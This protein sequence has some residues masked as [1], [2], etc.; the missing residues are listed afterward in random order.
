MKLGKAVFYMDNPELEH[1]PIDIEIPMLAYQ[2]DRETR[3]KTLSVVIQAEKVG[4]Q[5]L[6]GVRYF[7][8]GN[9]VCAL[10]EIEFIK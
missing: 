2:I 6:V 9:G 7:D 10:F 4:K 8:G 1:F 3:E 5:E